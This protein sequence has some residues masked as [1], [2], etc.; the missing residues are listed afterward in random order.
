MIAYATL[1]RKD[2]AV[3]IWYYSALL[4]KMQEGWRKNL[5]LSAINRNIRLVIDK[6]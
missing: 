2:L 6:N 1:R 3:T 5:Q 4:I